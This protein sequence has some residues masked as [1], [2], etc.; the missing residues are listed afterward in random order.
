MSN[1]KLLRGER[2]QNARRL[3]S[4]EPW[5]IP[6]CSGG[7]EI[8]TARAGS[9]WQQGEY[10]IAPGGARSKQLPALGLHRRQ[11]T[12]LLRGERDQNEN[13]LSFR[14]PTLIPNCSGGS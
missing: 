11:N 3:T 2:D 12:K 4:L 9:A 7:S 1:T 5:L 8:K 10:Q 6:N 14:R 13:H